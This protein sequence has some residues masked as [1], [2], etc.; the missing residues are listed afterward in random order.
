MTRAEGIRR[1]QSIRKHI[2][3]IKKDFDY[4]YNHLFDVAEKFSVDPNRAKKLIHDLW[5]DVAEIGESVENL[6]R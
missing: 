4:L 3:F 5:F 6:L 1:K 2:N